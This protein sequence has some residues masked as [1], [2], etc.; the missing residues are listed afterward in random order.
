MG[1]SRLRARVVVVYTLGALAA[2]AVSTCLYLW[3]FAVPFG[4]MRAF[5]MVLVGVLTVLLAVGAPRRTCTPC[6][7]HHE[8]L[9]GASIRWV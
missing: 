6:R 3:S 8:R 5:V 7:S 1:A 9:A 4:A 2:S